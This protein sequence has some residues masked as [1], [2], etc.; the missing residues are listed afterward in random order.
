MSQTTVWA[1]QP[2][3]ELNNETGFVSC[4][5]DLAKKLISSGMVDDP[6]IGAGFLREIQSKSY[7]TK[8]MMAAE[9][10]KNNNKRH[11]A[12]A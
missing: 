10:S 6:A 2:I 3:D 12:I 11:K 1:F 8:V 4:D 5:E 7:E 9:K